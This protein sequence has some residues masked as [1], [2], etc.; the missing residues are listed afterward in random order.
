M[1][2]FII[3]ATDSC[4]AMWRHTGAMWRHSDASI[5]SMSFSEFRSI[6]L[7]SFPMTCRESNFLS[8]WFQTKKFFKVFTERKNVSAAVQTNAEW[9][10]LENVEKVQFKVP[11][12]QD[13]WFKA[14]QSPY[15]LFQNFF[16]N[17]AQRLLQIA[18]YLSGNPISPLNIT[19]SKLQAFFSRYTNKASKTRG[20]VGLF[21]FYWLAISKLKRK[22]TKARLD[23]KA[24]PAL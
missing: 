8:N 19:V 11:E 14:R 5:A 6:N 15:S 1:L 21:Y 3:P 18:G 2:Y 7:I 12:S 23:F 10:V 24:A 17:R 16:F 22:G 20:Q 13:V 4:D 9:R